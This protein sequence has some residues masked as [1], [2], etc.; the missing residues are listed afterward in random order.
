M[1]RIMSSLHEG[2]RKIYKKGLPPEFFRQILLIFPVIINILAHFE[3][4]SYHVD[5]RKICHIQNVSHIQFNIAIDLGLNYMP[6][7]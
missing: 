4:Y 2:F 6:A 3:I 7:A 5:F 1:W